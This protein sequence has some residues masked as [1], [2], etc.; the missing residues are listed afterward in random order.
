MDTVRTG[1]TR[2]AEAYQSTAGAP[3]MAPRPRLFEAYRVTPGG[4]WTSPKDLL[5]QEFGASIRELSM[6]ATKDRLFV[7]YERSGF[8]ASES[9]DGRNWSAPVKLGSPLQWRT[10]ETGRNLV[11]S[12]DSDAVVVAWID[13]RFDWEQY[14]PNLGSNPGLHTDVLAIQSTG[15]PATLASLV[16]SPITRVTPESGPVMGVVARSGDG[17]H[18]IV[19]IEG[20]PP[21]RAPEIGVARLL[22]DTRR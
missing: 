7:I 12:S 22:D 2:V 4:A 18:E 13:R 1:D 14:V 20:L 3:W 10:S 11:A 8:E 15:H 9:T 17:R 19:W 16:V 6:V 21:T 5:P